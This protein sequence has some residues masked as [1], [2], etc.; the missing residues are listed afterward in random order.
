MLVR[1]LQF[2][3]SGAHCFDLGGGLTLEPIRKPGDQRLDGVTNASFPTALLGMALFHET[4]TAARLFASLRGRPSAD[5]P[6]TGISVDIASY[7]SLAS[8]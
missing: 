8:V 3:H 5:P 1:S 7:S 2:S 6:E 4:C